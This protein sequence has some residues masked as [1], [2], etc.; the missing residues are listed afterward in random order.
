VRVTDDGV[1][2]IE[3][4]LPEPRSTPVTLPEHD[5]ARATTMQRV[6][7]RVST[8]GSLPTAGKRRVA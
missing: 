6:V 4:T 1:R 5:H 8:T 2:S 3:A 7:R